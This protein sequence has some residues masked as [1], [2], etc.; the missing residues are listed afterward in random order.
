M[1][2]TL[3][4]PL[5]FPSVS[6]CVHNG[7]SNTSAAEELAKFIKI[8][9]FEEKKTIFNEHPPV[10]VREMDLNMDGLL[11]DGTIKMELGSG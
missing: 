5:G 4:P 10:H 3:A 2:L 9:T 11:T 1:F 6:E 7:R 8:T